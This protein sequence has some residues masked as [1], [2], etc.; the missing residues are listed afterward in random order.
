[1]AAIHLR[2]ANPAHVLHGI[3]AN[4][5]RSRDAALYHLK[6]PRGTALLDLSAGPEP[7]PRA[8]IGTAPQA[9]WGHRRY[10]VDLDLGGKICLGERRPTGRL[11]VVGRNARTRQNGGGY[12]QRGDGD[13]RADRA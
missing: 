10:P 5:D 12:A 8:S 6:N 13:G 11:D 9:R 2:T 7:R 1:M 4:A 3:T